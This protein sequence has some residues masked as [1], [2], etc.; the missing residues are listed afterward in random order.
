LRKDT[1][2]PI[3]LPFDETA[4]HV[5]RVVDILHRRGVELPALPA[6]VSA[7]DALVERLPSWVAR[8][9]AVSDGHNAW[10]YCA[11]RSGRKSGRPGQIVL[12]TRSDRC[13][14]D[15]FDAA[16]G[17]CIARESAGGTP[18]VAGLAFTGKPLVLWIRPI[19]A[20]FNVI[21]VGN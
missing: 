4:S 9:G 20:H 10:V 2:L 7:D 11:P 18:L 14:I 6:A 17:D 21:P 13:F 8:Y 5:Q 1:R 3:L 19:T 15:I 12:C 16:S